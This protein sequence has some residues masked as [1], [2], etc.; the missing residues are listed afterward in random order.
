MG[1]ISKQETETADEKVRNKVVNQFTN[2]TED[3]NKAIIQ[4]GKQEKI[5]LKKY[6]VLGRTPMHD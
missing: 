4:T 5:F 6:D 1:N 2:E 3:H